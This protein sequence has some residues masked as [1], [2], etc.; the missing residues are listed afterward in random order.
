MATRKA[1]YRVVTFREYAQPG[2]QN[3]LAA[4]PQTAWLH[5]L[6]EARQYCRAR[7]RVKISF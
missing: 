6:N 2:L 4:V 7:H 3:R 1:A 5:P